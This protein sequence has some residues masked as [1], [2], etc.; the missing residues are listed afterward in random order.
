[1]SLEQ[2]DQLI[3]SQFGLATR[4]MGPRAL[5]R[6]VRRRLDA[7]HLTSDQLDTY[8][9]AL[10]SSSTERQELLELLVVPETWF[11]RNER[12]FPY[13]ARYVMQEWLPANPVGRLRVLSLACAT[14]EEPYSILMALRDA[15]LPLDRISLEAVDISERAL[16]IAGVGIYGR[17]SFRSF[18]DRDVT[19][20]AHHLANVGQGL[21]QVRADLR[22]ALKIRQGNL[23]DRSLPAS[24]G[25]SRYDIVLCRNVMIYSPREG[26]QTVLNMLF[27][28]LGDQS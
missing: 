5:D 9:A 19:P 17:N 1:M 15:G 24:L 13:L 4:V 16:A 26:Q 28:L 12:V 20:I 7:L 14:G 3:L 25:H 8:V 27:G 21:W 22:S 6:A 23:H 10:R 11:F 2:I 18:A